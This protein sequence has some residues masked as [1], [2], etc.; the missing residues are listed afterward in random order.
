VAEVSTQL[1]GFCSDD[2]FEAGDPG[3]DDQATA[4]S[5]EIGA[6]QEHSWCPVGDKDWLSFQATQGQTL[7]FTSKAVG[8]NSAAAIRLY[9]TDGSTLLSD[10]HPN[11]ANS[12]TTLEWKVPADGTYYLR[13][14]PQDSKIGGE[15]AKYTISVTTDNQVNPATLICGSI[16][17]PALLGTGFVVA[18]KRYD[19]KKRS[20]RVGW[21]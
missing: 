16:T 18:K 7:T 12:S 10:Q 11:D 5:I 20:K 17:I 8:L 19:Q 13:L 1:N 3:D 21:K 4:T 14:S 15:D 9:N 2:A 6:E